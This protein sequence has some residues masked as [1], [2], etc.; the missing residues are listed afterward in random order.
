MCGTGGDEQGIRSPGCVDWRRIGGGLW[1]GRRGD[2]SIGTIEHT[3]RYVW[4][5][6]DGRPHDGRA[7]LREA[8]DD[9]IAEVAPPARPSGRLLGLIGWAVLALLVGAMWF[10]G[11][12]LLQP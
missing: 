10:T 11:W 4:V 12:Q 1:V 5:D 7:T 9:A 3:G 8:Q 2:R 6:C